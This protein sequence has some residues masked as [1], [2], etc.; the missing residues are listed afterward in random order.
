MPDGSAL[1]TSLRFW[2]RSI[3]FISI[4]NSIISSKISISY[5][6]R[7]HVY[8]HMNSNLRWIYGA[9]STRQFQYSKES[10]DIEHN[11]S[12]NPF[13]KMNGLYISMKK[14]WILRHG[15][16][17]SNIWNR[18]SIYLLNQRRPKAYPSYS[19]ICVSTALKAVLF[20]DF[21]EIRIFYFRKYFRL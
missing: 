6:F 5:A 7:V 4:Y 21:S 20:G 9:I 18:H 11:L 15:N 17:N 16:L 10:S 1:I 13:Q 8:S 12:P 3:D 14:H 2:I 19:P